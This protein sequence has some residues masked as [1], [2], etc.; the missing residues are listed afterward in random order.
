MKG[1]CTLAGG[2]HMPMQQAGIIPFRERGDHRLE[3]DWV[4]STR[5]VR[6][7]LNAAE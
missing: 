7:Y 5:V 1:Q 2:K 4:A 6:D 3:F